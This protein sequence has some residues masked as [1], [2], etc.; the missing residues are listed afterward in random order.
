M[1]ADR[2][3]LVVDRVRTEY[4]TGTVVGTAVPRL[5]WVVHRR[6]SPAG[7]HRSTELRRLDADGAVA[8]ETTVDG[9]ASVLVA[10]PFTPLTSRE[11]CSV[12]LRVL[13][14]DGD[15]SPWTD[16][17]E[18]SRP[19]CSRLVGLAR[20]PGHRRLPRRGPRAADPFPPHL[21]GRATGSPA[22]ASTSAPSG[23]YNAHVQRRA[24]GRRAAGPGLDLLPAPLRYATHDLTDQL[25]AGA[26]ALG[27]T[28]AEGWWRGRLGF[29]GGKRE[30]YG[31]QIGPIAQLELTY[32]DGSRDTVV[33][34]G[35][36]AGRPRPAPLRQPL[37]RRA[38]R[39][40]P[41]G[42][43][44]VDRRLRRLDL[45][46]GRRAGARRRSPGGPGRP[47]GPSHRDDR[48]PSTIIPVP[49]RRGARRLRPGDRRADPD[50]GRGAG[51]DRDHPP[52]RRGPR[53]R[54][55]GHPPAAPGRRP[56]TS[57]S[58]PEA[59]R[60]PTSRRSPATGSA[61]SRCRVGPASSTPSAIEAIFATS[62]LPTHGHVPL[63]ER[64]PEHAA[65]QHPSGLAGQRRRPAH[66]L[67]PARRAPR[68]DR[69]RPGLRPDGHLP[70]RLRR[71]PRLLAPGPRRRAGRVRRRPGVRAR[72]S[73]TSSPRARM[74]RRLVGCR[75]GRALARCTS[76]TATVDLLARQY[77][78]HA[79]H[80]RPTSPTSS[81]STA[82]PARASSWATGS[83]RAPR[84][85]TRA[86]ARTDAI[87]VAQAYYCRVRPARGRRRRRPRPTRRRGRATGRSPTRPRRRSAAS[88]SPRAVGWPATPRR[89]SP[90]PCSSTCCR[91]PRPAASG[92]AR[93]L[94]QLVASRPAPHRDRVPRH[95]ARARRPGR[96]RPPR[97]R[98][99]PAAAAGV[100]R[101]GSTRC[102][103][104]RR[105]SGS[106]GTACCPTAASTPAR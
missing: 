11:R 98:L 95:A 27:V 49:R 68:L 75:G 22:P 57:S 14:E 12:Q 60:R 62:D 103:W 100:P 29:M 91:T 67:P 25:V 50:P 64:R 26:N 52:P 71:V 3:A 58:S 85:T 9:E 55:V 34:D 93:R 47:A 83:T 38:L 79:G 35:V 41:R 24:G 28:V 104:G 66:R 53:A 4:G 80:G 43:G 51:R 1:T 13:G 96:R 82:W 81:T 89:P 73:P 92:P 72:A 31:E 7:E 88:S 94:A 63:L 44:V 48:R 37:R 15:P 10:W 90:S 17:L 45:G 101:R 70:D 40:P 86:A 106:A 30:N 99:P 23:T 36:L 18:P 20:R 8:E 77:D 97:R 32:E 87:L 102:G 76:A 69:R 42:P 78:E 46:A 84:P 16:P 19:A 59:A 54:R 74:G 2:P 39:R 5:S 65:R 33:T 105:R 21:R 6:P 56:P 61:T